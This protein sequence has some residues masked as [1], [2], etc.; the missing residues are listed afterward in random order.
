M[1][2]LGKLE[3][4]VESADL[5]AEFSD[6]GMGIFDPAA[7]KKYPEFV[8]FLE[9]NAE[10]GDFAEWI[11]EN[12]DEDEEPLQETVAPVLYHNNGFAMDVKSWKD[13]EGLDK[14]WESEYNEY[15]EEAGCFYVFEHEDVT[16]GKIEFLK[17]EGNVFRI[18]WSGTANV[19]WDDEYG[20]DVPF[21]FEGDVTFSELG[22]SFVGITDLEC[23]KAALSDYIDMDEFEFKSE[24]TRERLS[25]SEGMKTVHRFNFVPKI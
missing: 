18:R 17:R 6:A 12:T 7:K 8:W 13:L 23:V 14:T 3:F 15:G 9:I 16:S 19:F 24:E 22:T 1:L 25:S 10:E 20:E 5:F 11:P 4:E 2:K 21:E